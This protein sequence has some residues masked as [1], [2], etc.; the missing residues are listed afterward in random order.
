MS[1]E[2]TE[3]S[4]DITVQPSVLHEGVKIEAEVPFGTLDLLLDRSEALALSVQLT[5]CIDH[6]DRVEEADE[7]EET[8]GSTGRS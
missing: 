2:Q 8:T 7:S 1:S 6:L 4:D 3:L 5:G